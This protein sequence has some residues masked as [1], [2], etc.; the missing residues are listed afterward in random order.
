MQ[1]VF[2]RLETQQVTPSVS[3]RSYLYA[4]V[5]NHA[6]D[7]LR[8]RSRQSLLQADDPPFWGIPAAQS[9]GE[10]QLLVRQELTLLQEALAQLPPQ[11]RQALELHRFARQSFEQIGKRLGVSTAT[12]H[13]YVRAGLVK[14]TVA[15]GH[16]ALDNRVMD[17]QA[18]DNQA[19]ETR[20]A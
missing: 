13:R 3:W 15:M 14:L 8:R 10:D 7:A 12:A 5:R 19:G 16:H 9:T 1:D 4:M 11:E 6:I 18:V 17:K 20:D 2:V